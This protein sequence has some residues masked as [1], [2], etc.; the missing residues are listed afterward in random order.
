MLQP[1]ERSYYLDVGDVEVLLRDQPD[2]LRVLA[3]SPE[4]CSF[5]PRVH[6][7]CHALRAVELS[8]VSLCHD[9]QSN[10]GDPERPSYHLPQLGGRL[11]DP[12]DRDVVPLRLLH[13]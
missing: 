13:E 1:L 3:A 11:V 5:P 7:D 10:G 12:Y 6:D 8:K 2:L 4:Y 9:A